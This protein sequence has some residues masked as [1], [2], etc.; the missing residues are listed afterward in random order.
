MPL[1]L[2]HCD[3][4]CVSDACLHLVRRYRQLIWIGYE[5]VLYR[6]RAGVLQRRL[7]DLWAA[8]VTA[9]PVTLQ[10]RAAACRFE[11]ETGR[12]VPGH[13]ADAAVRKAQAVACYASQLK[14]LGI[15]VAG[16]DGADEGYWLL[17]AAA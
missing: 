7:A 6:R 2:F 1:G 11:Q 5:D 3:H 4:L 15:A 10:G 13:L 8:G 9:T 14:C 16:D 12:A 17:S